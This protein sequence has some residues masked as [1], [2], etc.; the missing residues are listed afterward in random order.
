MDDSIAKPIGREMDIL[1]TCAVRAD[2][3]YAVMKRF[4]RHMCPNTRPM[5]GV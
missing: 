2:A 5:T 4:G 1:A 3:G